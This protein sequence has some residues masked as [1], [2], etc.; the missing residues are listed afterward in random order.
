MSELYEVL[1]TQLQRAIVNEDGVFN[2][3]SSDSLTL[4][5]MQDEVVNNLSGLSEIDP[6]KKT[7]TPE[8]KA[9]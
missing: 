7:F 3:L 5:V 2:T 6:D 1:N 8:P 4:S 9:T